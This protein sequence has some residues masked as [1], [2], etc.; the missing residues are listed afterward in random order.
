ML[1]M[2]SRYKKNTVEISSRRTKNTVQIGSGYVVNTVETFSE[3]AVNVQ[4]RYLFLHVLPELSS[5]FYFMIE[6]GLEVQPSPSAPK[7]SLIYP[8]PLL[9]SQDE[10]PPYP[11]SPS[12]SPEQRLFEWL[13]LLGDG[14]SMA[15]EKHHLCE[16]V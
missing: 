11:V 7:D 12:N 5:S 13:G 10:L 9:D 4:R 16:V 2:Y 8:R 14:C 15:S 6:L 3:H 1:L